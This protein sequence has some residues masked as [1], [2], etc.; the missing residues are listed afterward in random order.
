MRFSWPIWIYEQSLDKVPGFIGSLKHTH[1]YL[2]SPFPQR[3][4]CIF[5]QVYVMGEFLTSRGM[6]FNTDS[7]ELATLGPF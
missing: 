2:C 4:W 3:V 1:F 6:L 5:F 7:P